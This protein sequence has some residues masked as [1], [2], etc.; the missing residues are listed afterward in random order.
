MSKTLRVFPRKTKATPD[1][2]FVVIDR[3]PTLWDE[4]DAIHISVS[5]DWDVEK[6]LRLADAWKVVAPV[7]L[8][9]PAM[10]SIPGE[11]TPGMYLKH[12]Y[13]ITSRGCPWNCDFC[14]VPKREGK[15]RLLTIKPGWDVLDNNLLACPRN[16]IEA[17]FAMLKTQSHPV[18]FTGGLE[19]GLLR[20][21]HVDELLKLKPDTLWL[22][23]DSPDDWE[24]LLAATK[25]LKDA[26]IVWPHR[27]KRA[28]AY[29]LM[30]RHYDTPDD[31]ERR[32]LQ[33][34]NL[35][36]KTQAILFDNGHE[37]KPEDM[38]R[39]WDLRKKY[40]DSI[41]VGAMIAATWK[42]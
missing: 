42:T 28:G 32:L 3:L 10:G 9:G 39:W 34:I 37:C 35:G 7:E 25:L 19:A 14:L 23:Y 20:S 12:G 27:R 40:T 1:D 30:G 16:H 6:A 31:A 22:A 33:V 4:A 21:W 8:G 24:P 41:S 26:G 13:T 36:L 15:L 17:V 38:P 5:F 18:K 2:E 29:V 11:F